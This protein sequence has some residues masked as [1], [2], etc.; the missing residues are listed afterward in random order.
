MKAIFCFIEGAL[1]IILGVLTVVDAALHSEKAGKVL[2]MIS[3]V[4]FVATGI[5]HCLLGCREFKEQHL[6]DAELES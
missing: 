4:G 2:S 6:P 1:Q 3:G 5:L